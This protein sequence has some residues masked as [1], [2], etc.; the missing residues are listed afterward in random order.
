MNA[1]DFQVF[2]RHAELG[3]LAVVTGLDI[4]LPGGIPLKEWDSWHSLI[5]TDELGRV[6]S[7]CFM[8]ANLLLIPQGV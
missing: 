8:S 3:Y 6:V 1:D 7:R 2:K 4:P 5:L